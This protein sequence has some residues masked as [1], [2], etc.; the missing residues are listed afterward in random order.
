MY[1]E[2]WKRSQFAP[3]ATIK[4]NYYTLYKLLRF[5]IHRVFLEPRKVYEQSTWVGPV[6][7]TLM[8]EAEANPE[9]GKMTGFI[10]L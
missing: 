9:A 1:K 10:S 7:E 3:V 2:S 8:G 6:E 4:I 5:Y